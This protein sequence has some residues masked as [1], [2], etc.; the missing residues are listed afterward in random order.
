MRGPL[1]ELGLE[2]ALDTML[3][4]L[5]TDR[6]EEFADRLF[7]KAFSTSKN[8]IMKDYNGILCGT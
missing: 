6:F 2:A 4:L 7:I 8:R 3:R 5:D 1:H